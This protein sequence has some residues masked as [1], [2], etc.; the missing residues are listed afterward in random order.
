MILYTDDANTFSQKNNFTKTMHKVNT[1]LNELAPWASNWLTNSDKTNYILFK[2][3]RDGRFKLVLQDKVPKNI[4]STKFFAIHFH[5]NLTWS[6]NISHLR[7][8]VSTTVGALNKG[9]F[10]QEQITHVC[11]TA[12]WFGELQQKVTCKA[13][14]SSGEKQLGL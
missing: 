13:S 5:E 8:H 12:C 7:T 9:L 4:Q 10:L 11:L 14:I 2:Q 6:T 1:W 3:I